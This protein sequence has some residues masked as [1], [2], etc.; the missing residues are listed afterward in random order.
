M[1]DQNS[2]IVTYVNVRS[3]HAHFEDILSD[4]ILM[5]SDAFGLG[6]TWEEEGYPERVID[7]FQGFSD[8]KPPGKGRGKGLSAFTKL[9]CSF[10]KFASIEGNFSAIF[11]YFLKATTE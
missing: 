4:P 6:E 2:V 3:L 11:H 9:D 7:G 1:E 8:V 10:R 5:K